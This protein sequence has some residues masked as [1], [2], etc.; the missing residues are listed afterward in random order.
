MKWREATGNSPY[1]YKVATEGFSSTFC[2]TS[3]GLEAPTLLHRQRAPLEEYYFQWGGNSTRKARC[4]FNR[5]TFGGSSTFYNMAYMA[6]HRPEPSA[7]PDT[8]VWT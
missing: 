8:V 4:Q 3:F 1:H 5:Y 2:T 7:T 6:A